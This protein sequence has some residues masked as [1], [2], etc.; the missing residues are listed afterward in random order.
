MIRFI[1]VFS[2]FISSV[3]AIDVYDVKNW[4]DIGQYNRICQDSVRDLF[5][6][7]QDESI[8]NIYAN[9]CLKMDKISELIIPMVMLYKTKD[10]RENAALYSTILFQKKMLYLALADKVDISYIRTPKI[11]YVLSMVFDKFVQ[12]EY[13]LK[14]NIYSMVLDD[15]QHCDLLMKEENGIKQMVVL[16]YKNGKINSVKKYW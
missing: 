6:S 11:N 9:A 10:Q 15:S 4:N 12:G 1:L 2:I 7:K 14:N 16:L 8:A 5:I 13:T 3:L